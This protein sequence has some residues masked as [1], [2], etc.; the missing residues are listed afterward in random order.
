MLLEA[1]QDSPVINHQNSMGK[2]PL[3]EITKYM[4]YKAVSTLLEKGAD[5]KI[6]DNLGNTPLHNVVNNLDCVCSKK[7]LKTIQ[8]LLA[9]EKW[10]Q[11]KLKN[12]YNQTAL[13]IAVDKNEYKIVNYFLNNTLIDVSKT[14][15]LFNKLFEDL[16]KTNNMFDAKKMISSFRRHGA[17]IFGSST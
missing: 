10:L 17:V 8:I 16:F 2:T 3:S 4:K 15:V 5:V 11:S 1:T 7:G 9:K 14:T 6:S 13:E 12:M